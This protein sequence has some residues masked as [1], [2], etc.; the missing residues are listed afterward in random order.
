MRTR[1]STPAVSVLL[2]AVFDQLTSRRLEVTL[3]NSLDSAEAFSTVQYS[4]VEVLSARCIGMWTIP[5]AS[6]N[7]LY[8]GPD[9][10]GNKI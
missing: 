5:T 7:A 9:E 2:D 3:K 1:R 4:R 8:N 6:L 10:P